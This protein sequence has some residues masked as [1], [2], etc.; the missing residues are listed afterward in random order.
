[1]RHITAPLWL[2]GAA[3]VALSPAAAVAQTGVFCFQ[4]DVLGAPANFVLTADSREVAQTATAAALAEIDRLD[5]ILSGYSPKSELAE[6]NRSRTMKVSEDLF[7]VIERAEQMRLSTDGAFDGRL[8]AVERLWRQTGDALPDRGQ[9]MRAAWDARAPVELNAAKGEISRPDGVV[10]S[11]DAIAKGYIVDRA[12]EAAQRAAPLAG[13]MI[14]IGGDMRCA[15]RAGAETSWQVG[16]PDPRLPF[17]NAPLVARVQLRDQAIATSGRGPRDR[18]I[19]G[20][21]Y[22]PTFS[23]E[24]GWAATSNLSATVVGPTAEQADALATALLVMEPDRGLALLDRF[25]NVHA[26]VTTAE[27]EVFTSAGWTD[28]QG[29]PQLLKITNSRAPQR[30]PGKSAARTPVAPPGPAVGKSGWLVD[31]ALQVLYEAPEVNLSRRD[32]DYRTPYMA[33]WISDK[34]NRPIRTLVLVGKD[35]DWQRENHIWWSL[36][37]G[38]AQKLVELRSTGTALSGRYPTFWPG[39]NDDWNFVPPGEYLL[40]IETS[41]ERGQHTHRAIPL[42]LGRTAF[43]TKV[44]PTEE[45]GGLTI[46]YRK[47]D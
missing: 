11:L 45:G 31:W 12:L 9:L 8:G 26:R 29:E 37:G 41:R 21:L 42:T 15:G 20:K 22:S 23:S 44:A 33:M 6:L 34:D 25:S 27:G 14:D 38:R 36:Y 17:V 2:I 46:A 28:T 40:H 4:A 24:T 18:V 43:N 13:L 30:T 39:Y 32:A 19:E 3:G 16:L 35:P 1:M 5:R 7:A 10:F 47:R